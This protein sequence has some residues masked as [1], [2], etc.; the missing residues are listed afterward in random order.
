[1]DKRALK[2]WK[3]RCLFCGESRYESLQVHRVVPGKDGGRYAEGNVTVLCANCHSQVT[4]GRLKVLRLYRSTFAHWVAHCV[5]N[6]EEKW[7]EA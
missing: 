2:R 1:M 5:V 4:A 3:G 7:L 6:G